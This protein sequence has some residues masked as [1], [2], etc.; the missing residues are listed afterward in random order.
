MGKLDDKVAIITGSTRGIGKAIARA[1]VKE[2]ARVVITSSREA[3]VDAALNDFPK[4]S[5]FGHV[6][7][8]SNY[9]DVEKL[10]TKTVGQFG[11]LDVFINNAGISD[12]F[13]NI[14]DGDPREW[15][16]VIDINLKGTYY[17]TRA[18]LNHFLEAGHSGKIINMAGSGT[19]KKSNTPYISAYGSSKAAIARFTFA[20]AEEYKNTPVSIMLLHPGLVR[21]DM[22]SADQSTPEMKRRQATFRT[23]VDIFSQPPSVAASLAVKMA[24]EKGGCKNGDYLS[25]L[26]RKRRKWLLFS[27]PFRKLFRKIDRTSY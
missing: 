10:V 7:D 6:C 20:V 14:T 2:G 5:V 3:N 1:F 4:Q 17:G 25:A 24:V 11:K 23:I 9:T 22:T 15:G 21:T 16:Q 8:V 13:Y 26:D 27:Y 18:A 19:D 12:T